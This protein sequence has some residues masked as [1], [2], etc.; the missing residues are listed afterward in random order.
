MRGLTSFEVSVVM[1]WVISLCAS[2]AIGS[3]VALVCK[4]A[5]FQDELREVGG[6][7]MEESQA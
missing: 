1:L 7:G 4:M 2:F 5:D 6:S 3:M